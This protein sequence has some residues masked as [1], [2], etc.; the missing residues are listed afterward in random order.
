MQQ[1]VPLVLSLHL[2]TR[3]T[4]EGLQSARNGQI[5]LHDPPQ[6]PSRV[7]LGSV[8]LGD[9]VCPPSTVFSAYNVYGGGD[10]DIRVYPYNGHEGGGAHHVREQF[11]F[12]RRR[13]SS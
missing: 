2:G 3:R 1:P 11:A 5:R 13:L 7:K 8:G 12:A 4:L 10:K 6:T 9:E